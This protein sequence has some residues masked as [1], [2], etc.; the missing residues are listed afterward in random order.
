MCNSCWHAAKPHQSEVQDVHVH[1]LV[2][3][4]VTTKVPSCKALICVYTDVSSLSSL[5]FKRGSLDVLL[6]LTTL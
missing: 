3:V 2:S 1:C 6:T 4:L 5:H